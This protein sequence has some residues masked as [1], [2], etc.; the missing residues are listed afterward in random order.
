MQ[1]AIDGSD[2]KISSTTPWAF[3]TSIS[4]KRIIAVYDSA[5][6][7]LRFRVSGKGLSRTLET[8]HQSHHSTGAAFL[9]T[10]ATRKPAKSHIPISN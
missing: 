2:E 3:L 9:F 5:V 7:R 8:P 4:L 6:E 10:V 1:V